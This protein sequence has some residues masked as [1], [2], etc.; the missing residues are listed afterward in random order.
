[1][2]ANQR[3]RTRK[4]L[5]GWVVYFESEGPLEM[6]ELSAKVIEQLSEE[7]TRDDLIAFVKENYPYAN[8]EVEVDEVIE[9]L[10]NFSLLSL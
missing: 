2:K 9:T 6:P 8:A 10:N 4:D 3:F 5:K 7:K 1:M